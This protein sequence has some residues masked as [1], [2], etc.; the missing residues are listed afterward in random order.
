MQINAAPDG[1]RIIRWV[2]KRR[3]ASRTFYF[4]TS[5]IIS[6]SKYFNLWCTPRESAFVTTERAP[7]SFGS[8]RWWWWFYSRIIVTVSS[9]SC[10]SIECVCND[11]GVAFRV[12]V[13]VFAGW[14][15]CCTFFERLAVFFFRYFS[16]W[17][18]YRSGK[19]DVG[20]LW[21]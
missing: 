15:W 10:S 20:F 13:V 7:R 3:A 5:L 21:F 9:G 2:N 11:D 18:L 17:F 19:V 4:G 6:V 12:K 14:G 8:R 16:V 1:I